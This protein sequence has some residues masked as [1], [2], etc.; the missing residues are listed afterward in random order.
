M[1][2]AALLFILGLL[3]VSPFCLCPLRHVCRVPQPGR[4]HL[5]VHCNTHE[6]SLE[7]RCA[8]CRYRQLQVA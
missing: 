2:A 6:F 4:F 3:I 1:E 7:L 5:H 8:N